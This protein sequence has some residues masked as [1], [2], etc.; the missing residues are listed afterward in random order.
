MNDTKPGFLV[1]G[2]DGGNGGC[3]RKGGGS[4]PPSIGVLESEEFKKEDNRGCCI[5]KMSFPQE[6]NFHSI[7]S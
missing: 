2:A 4:V 1:E 5:T 6:D 3:R 7:G